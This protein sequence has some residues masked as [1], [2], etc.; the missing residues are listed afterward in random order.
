MLGPKEMANLYSI[1]DKEKESI[2]LL[3]YFTASGKVLPVLIIYPYERIPAEIV[4]N[5][6]EG[7]ASGKSPK[8][9]M[10]SRV[11]YGYI[12]NT[13]LP[14]LHESNVKFPVVFL[15]DGTKSVNFVMT[16]K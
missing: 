15:I 3:G 12:A 1:K 5:V 6:P 10:T 11:F 9:W 14:A 16:I 4:R 2:T 7:W 8:G 13:L